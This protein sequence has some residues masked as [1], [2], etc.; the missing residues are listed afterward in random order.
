MDIE[1]LRTNIDGETNPLLVATELGFFISDALKDSK[2]SLYEA[3]YLKELEY[4]L[5]IQGYQKP[6]FSYT[7]GISLLLSLE[8]LYLL[9]AYFQEEELAKNLLS[10]ILLAKD[11]NGEDRDHYSKIVADS[12]LKDDLRAAL[13]ELSKIRNGSKPYNNGPYNDEVFPWGYISPEDELLAQRT[14]NKK[15]ISSEISEII[16]EIWVT[17]G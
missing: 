4:S 13:Q 7:I 12:L 1:E 8:M 9:A 11:K 16:S 10:K 5:L 15:P 17:H 3:M 2:I 6:A 14:G